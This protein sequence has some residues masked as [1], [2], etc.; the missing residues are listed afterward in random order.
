MPTIEANQL[1]T[2]ASNLRVTLGVIG[3]FAAV[4]GLL[5]LFFP[6][7]SGIIAM[8]ILAAMLAVYALIVGIA[9]I[10]NA[11]FSKTLRGW[12]RVGNA[13]LGLLYILAAVVITINLTET[14][15]VL[16]IFIAIFIGV[17]WLFE[18]VMA[19][20]TLNES[21]SKGWS[22]FYGI[23]SIIAGLSLAISPLL[24]AVM[25]WWL[26]GIMLLVLGIM[27]IV[28]AFTIKPK[29]FAGVE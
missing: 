23:V 15:A 29:K 18:G 1:K 19:L 27:Q 3:L 7:E 22:A 9:Y 17:A 26:L 28:R 4:I 21:P 5:I 25:L 12:A 2:G 20:S 8:D 16:A 6:G 24:G 11:I 10:G 14:A 13:L